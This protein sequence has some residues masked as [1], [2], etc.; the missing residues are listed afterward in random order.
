MYN[1]TFVSFNDLI[2]YSCS[3]SSS[4]NSFRPF[5]AEHTSGVPTNA[6]PADG[7][8]L[9]KDHLQVLR[10]LL[11]LMDHGCRLETRRHILSLVLIPDNCSNYMEAIPLK[12]TCGT[13]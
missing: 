5:G 6:G 3:C 9:M 10:G 12:T 13:E 2:P 8:M 11:L 7:L 4:A 1:L